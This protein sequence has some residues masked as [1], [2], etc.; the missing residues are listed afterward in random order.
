[1][2]VLTFFGIDLQKLLLGFIGS[3]FGWVADVLE[4]ALFDKPAPP[5]PDL[6][7]PF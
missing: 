2:D 6:P 3:V 5:F 1:M 4:G 7:N